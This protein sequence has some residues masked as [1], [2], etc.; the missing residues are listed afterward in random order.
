MVFTRVVPPESIQVGDD[1]TIYIGGGQS[2][3]FL[4]HRVVEVITSESGDISFRTRG[5]NNRS[6]D[7]APFGSHLLAGKVVLCIPYLGTV[8]TFVQSQLVFVIIGF[9]LLTA[10]AF[11]L[12]LMFAKD[13]EQEQLEL[14]RKQMLEGAA[15]Q[16]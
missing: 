1:I 9:V 11:M 6:N 12:R 13:P 4:T 14:L 16:S 10:L 5:I 7:P 8:M 15:K 2:D 3:T